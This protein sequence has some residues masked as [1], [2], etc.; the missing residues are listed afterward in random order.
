MHLVY[1]KYQIPWVSITA[2]H[3]EFSSC[4]GGWLC[5]SRGATTHCCSPASWEGIT[6]LTQERIK[7]CKFWNSTQRQ[8]TIAPASPA[9]EVGQALCLHGLTKLSPLRLRTCS[10]GLCSP[11]W[12]LVGSIAN[13]WCKHLPS[14]LPSQWCGCTPPCWVSDPWFLVYTGFVLAHDFTLIPLSFLLSY[15]GTWCLSKARV[16]CR[17]RLWREPCVLS[18]VGLWLHKVYRILPSPT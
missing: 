5:D 9:I 13:L 1:L 17:W 14:T 12:T 7:A 4:P 3:K 11:V 6:R 18:H 15:C 2:H 8:P 16:L 10:R